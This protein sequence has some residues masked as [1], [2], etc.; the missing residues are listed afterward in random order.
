MGFEPTTSGLVRS[1]FVI[2]VLVL[3]IA[4]A[5]SVSPWVQVNVDFEDAFSWGQPMPKFW[6][7]TGLC[8]PVPRSRSEEFLLS[9]DSMLNLAMIGSLPRP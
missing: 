3:L 2:L 8:P 9:A 5:E 6:T 7:S 1:M 4:T